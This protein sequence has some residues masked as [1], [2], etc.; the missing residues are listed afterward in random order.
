[1]DNSR[2]YKMAFSG[3]YP[4]Y[5]TKVEKKG[6]TRQ[7]LDEVICWLTGYDATSLH[8]QIDR[9]VDMQTFFAEAP[10]LHPNAPKITGVICGYRIEE[11]EDELMRKVR[12]MDKLVDE[13]A[14]GRPMEKILRK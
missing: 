6:R 12:Y 5:I 13:L 4:H 2:V 7:E 8:G 1:M 11:I 10:Q 3:V 14:K 9:K